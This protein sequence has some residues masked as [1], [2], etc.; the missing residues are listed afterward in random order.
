MYR[1]LS[2]IVLTLL[3][4]AAIDTACGKTTEPLAITPASV[5][6]AMIAAT[7]TAEPK[8][9]A[10]P[11]TQP[12]VP[13][14]QS[15]KTTANADVTQVRAVQ[16]IGGTWTF[17]VTVQHPDIGW[18]DYADGWD[19]VAPDGI[20]LKPDPESRFTRTLLH[21]HQNEQPFTRSQSGIV[22]PEGITEVSVQAHD[23]VDGFGG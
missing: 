1:R 17:Q 4:M 18:E 20:V 6:P 14:P 21:P 23:I 19:V 13:S 9:E 22:I 7:P 5:P 2:L 10:S 8:P 16:S 15:S 11:T 12:E 3:T